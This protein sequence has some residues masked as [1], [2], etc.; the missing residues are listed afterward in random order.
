M[1]FS[2]IISRWLGVGRT[3][4]D[5]EPC[6]L[7]WVI[8]QDIDRSRS[9]PPNF[10]AGAG[11][12]WCCCL[13]ICLHSLPISYS[14]RPLPQ[15]LRM[16]KREVHQSFF[17]DFQTAFVS[18]VFFLL[19]PRFDQRHAFHLDSSS[20]TEPSWGD[21]D[22]TLSTRKA[23]PLAASQGAPE[24]PEGRADAQRSWGQRGERRFS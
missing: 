2:E 17:P 22:T 3:A 5:R 1:N 11:H 14:I 4:W 20:G 9:G 16:T 10:R 18:L 19:Q 23:L 8:V 12:C 24:R 13:T 7:W 6:H 21:N 15:P